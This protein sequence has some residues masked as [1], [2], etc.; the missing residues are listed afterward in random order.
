MTGVDDAGC[1]KAWW[2]STTSLLTYRIKL[3]N[4]DG[5]INGRIPMVKEGLD[6][7]IFCRH[8]QQMS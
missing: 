5:T 7:V 3:K 2:P 6:V 4:R 8:Q 1:L